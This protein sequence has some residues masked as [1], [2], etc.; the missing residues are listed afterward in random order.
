MGSSGRR[1]AGGFLGEKKT[2]AV[3]AP[4]EIALNLKAADEDSTFKYDE[5]ARNFVAEKPVLAYILKSALDEYADYT[6]QEIAERFIEGDPEIKEAA[7]HQDHPDKKRGLGMMSGD[8]KAEGLSTV[9]KS[10]RDGTVYFDIRFFAVLPLSGELMEVFVN[11]EIQ[12]N[13]TPGPIP[14]TDI[15]LQKSA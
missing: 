7:V 12:N 11:V 14:S 4:S 8:D 2:A 6:V 10:Q 5:S 1:E 15:P 9:D 13:D 3:S